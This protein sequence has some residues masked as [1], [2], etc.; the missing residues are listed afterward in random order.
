MEFR[1]Y[2]VQAAGVTMNNFW[3]TLLCDDPS[4]SNILVRNLKINFSIPII[5]YHYKL[6]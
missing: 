5:L 1:P 6:I 4:Q 3:K 2:L